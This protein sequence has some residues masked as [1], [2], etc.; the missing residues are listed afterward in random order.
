MADSLGSRL[1]ARL[2]S[3]ALLRALFRLVLL[4]ILFA[5]SVFFAVAAYLSFYNT[6]V[7]V[8]GVNVDVWLQYGL[9]RPPFAVVDLTEQSPLISLDQPYA[10][11][12]EL[13]VPSNE[14]N[15]NIGVFA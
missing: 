15:L 10:V 5:V 3:P 13:A 9:G 4:T 8:R 7:P 12:L 1:L 2:T 6:Y 11:S 14:R